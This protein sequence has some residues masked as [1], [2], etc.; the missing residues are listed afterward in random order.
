MAQPFFKSPS[1][2]AWADVL[3]L[4]APPVVGKAGNEGCQ[5]LH[6][7]KLPAPLPTG[8]GAE[9]ADVH[10]GV[11]LNNLKLPLKIW[12]VVGHGV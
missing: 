12:K 10:G 4:H 11:P 7:R 3:R 8:Y 9:G 1:S 6:I 2:S 5:G